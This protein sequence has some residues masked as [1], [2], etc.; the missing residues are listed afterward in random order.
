MGVSVLANRREKK[1]TAKFR[2][3]HRVETNY[4]KWQERR[5]DAH[6]QL[7]KA[8]HLREMAAK[9]PRLKNKA[10]HQ[11]RLAK[12]AVRK[13]KIAAKKAGRANW[14]DFGKKLLDFAT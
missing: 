14:N 1:L 2:R 6:H 11:R 13:A 10:E 4:K 7:A 5:E 9:N 3:Q 8:A 12:E